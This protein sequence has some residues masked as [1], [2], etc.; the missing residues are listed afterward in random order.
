MTTT[1]RARGRAEALAALTAAGAIGAAVALAPP[2]AAAIPGPTYHGGGLELIALDLPAGTATGYALDVNDDG[3][4]I[5]QAWDNAFNQKGVVWRDGV[6]TTIPGAMP[7]QVNDSGQVVGSLYSDTGQS[8]GFVWE[9]GT[10]TTLEPTDPGPDRYSYAGSISADGTVVGLSGTNTPLAD[11]DPTEGATKQAPAGEAG[12]EEADDVFPDYQPQIRA[13]VWRN[14]TAVDLGTLGGSWSS[15]DLINDHGQVAGSSATADGSEH[16]FLSGPGGLR[17]LGTLGGPSSTPLDINN[18]GQ[19]VGVSET[20]D[21]HSHAFLWENGR[22]RDLGTAAGLTES[23]AVAINERGQVLVES[24]EQISYPFEG[25]PTSTVGIFPAHTASTAYIWTAGQQQAVTGLG[26]NTF[27][28]VKLAD[29]GTV[30]GSAVTPDGVD[31]PWLWSGGVPH[32]LSGPAPLQPGQA[33]GINRSG[34]VVGHAGSF[35]KQVPVIWRR[36]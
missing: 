20:A 16:A 34:L 8:R 3:V 10:L 9:N 12:S 17:D 13:T 19:V 5:G 25:E 2:A 29:D 32:D 21:R 33:S 18:R 30:I 11:Y 26:G 1:T 14:G 7:W 27:S 15:A 35:T 23:S 28:P 36:T 6:P 22:M 31:R 4:V 24:H